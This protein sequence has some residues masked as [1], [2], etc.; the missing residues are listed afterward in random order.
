[1]ALG[2]LPRVYIEKEGVSS[3]YLF[4]RE[5]SLERKVRVSSLVEIFVRSVVVALC[6]YREK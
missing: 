2:C 1:M 4:E 6:K 5:L 3:W